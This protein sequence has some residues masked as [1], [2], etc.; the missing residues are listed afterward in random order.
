[1]FAVVFSFKFSNQYF[2]YILHLPH[3][4]HVSQPCYSSRCDHFNHLCRARSVKILFIWFPPPSVS[5]SRLGPDVLLSKD[6][7]LTDPLNLCSFLNTE[8]QA[9]HTHASKVNSICT[10]WHGVT[11]TAT[12]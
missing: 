3:A 9:W 11:F 2:V 4:S 6:L 12:V 8:D 7:L 10:S 5:S 1:V